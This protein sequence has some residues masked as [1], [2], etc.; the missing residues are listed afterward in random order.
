MINEV[1]NKRVLIISHNCL[2]LTGSNGRTLRNYLQGWP[3]DKLAQL[4]IHPEVPDFDIC[5]RYFCVSDSDVMR[6]I[7]KRVEAGHAVDNI[8]SRTNKDNTKAS[9]KRAKN[10]F[11]FILREMAWNSRLWSTSS[12]WKWIDDFQPEAILFQA[13]DAGF[14]F[15]LAADIA[16]R[17]Q[18]PVILYN[19]EGYYFKKVSYLQENSLSRLVYPCLHRYFCR[20]YRKL[21][22]KTTLSIYNCDMLAN[23]YEKAF[24]HKHAVVLNSSEFAENDFVPSKEKEHHIVYAGNVGVGRHKSIIAFAETAHKIDPS[25]SIDVFASIK[26]DVVKQEMERCSGINLQGFVTYAELQIILKKAEYLLHVE[27]FDAFYCEDLKYA[28]S[29]KIADSL[30][31]GNCLIVYAPASIAV[32][33]Y[34]QGKDAAVLIAGEDEL[35]EKLKAIFYDQAKREKMGENGRKLALQ[36]HSINQNRNRF[37]EYLREAIDNEGSAS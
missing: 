13:G 26:D 34:L 1:S 33:Q 19:T 20:Q 18:I 21:I 31:T 28:F 23:D 14:L 32:S 35:E 27:N 16:S 37:Q 17:Y 30:A 8:V 25:I 29:T 15:R 22:Q 2:S 4:Y 10:S 9:A 36:N 24:H 12:M 5:E 7:I 6:S 3:K 11:M